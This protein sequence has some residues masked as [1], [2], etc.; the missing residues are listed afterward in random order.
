MISLLSIFQ[1]LA[2][3]AVMFPTLGLSAQWAV[4]ISERAI[5][6][7]DPQMSASIGF[8]A[9]G[10]KIRV[11]E[12]AKNNGKVLPVIV[13]KRV[14]YVRVSDLET[15]SKEA[16][17]GSRSERM[18]DRNMKNMG[19]NKYG[20]VLGGGISSVD[21]PQSATTDNRYTIF[22]KGGGFR[23][24][25]ELH[26]SKTGIKGS[27]LYMTGT[28]DQEEINYIELPFDFYYKLVNTRSL[29]LHLFGGLSLI[30]FAEYKLGNLFTLNGTG[31]G[32]QVGSEL[33]FKLT[34][35]NFHLEG[36]YQYKKL[37]GF[38][39]PENDSYPEELEPAMSGLQIVAG[40]STSF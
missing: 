24:Y 21:F 4:V 14:A 8:I 26:N 27:L 25:R 11:G 17:V 18:L 39:L 37:Q 12:I 31:Y 28:R 15:S 36:S 5:V 10:K 3:V 7:A 35:L 2:L 34:D 23:A 19:R 9:K 32:T 16:A 6:Y 13:S 1:R 38:E 40:V 29:E 22:F 33:L 30:P 20:V